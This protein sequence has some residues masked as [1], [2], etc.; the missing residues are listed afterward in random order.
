[1]IS[2]L[3]GIQPLTEYKIQTTSS[4]PAKTHLPAL[5]II[6]LVFENFIK[7]TNTTIEFKNFNKGSNKTIELLLIKLFILGN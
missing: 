1:L 6:F 2:S 7:V 5:L 4:S 3:A